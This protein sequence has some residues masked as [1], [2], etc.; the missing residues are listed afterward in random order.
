MICDICHERPA[1]AVKVTVVNG[2]R[3]QEAYCEKCL[4]EAIQQSPDP[5]AFLGLA[6]SPLA[7]M[8]SGGIDQFLAQVFGQAGQVFGLQGSTR[9][10][11]GAVP[12]GPG[13]GDTSQDGVGMMFGQF[14][15]AVPGAERPHRR[16]GGIASFAR[17]LVELA[18]AGRL[19]P[20]VG[21]EKEIN[22][23]IE[24]LG[25]KSKN[26]AVL[27]GDPGVGKTAIVE[28]LAQRIATGRVPEF[29]SGKH[30]W[31]LDLAGALAGT[32]YRGEFEARM[33]SLLSELQSRRDGI[34][35]IDELHT[36]L[37][38]G[39]A[40]GGM[41][42][43][44]ILK[45]VLARGDIQVIG[46]TTL[47]EY[48]RYIEKDGALSRR[49]QPIMVGEPTAAETLAILEGLKPAYESYHRVKISPE[50]LE[51]CVRL[52][53]R[54]VRDRFQP[55]KAIDVMD[56]AMARAAIQ[57]TDATLQKRL[58]EIKAEKEKAVAN[59]EF[60]RA[61]ALRDEERSLRAKLAGQK[62]QS[63]VGPDDVA[64]VVAEWT[65]IPVER[66]GS[67]ESARLVNLEER[68][69]RRVIGQRAALEEVARAI[70]RARSGLKDPRRPVGSFLFLGPTGV[71][72]TETARALAAEL[73][74]SED[75]MIRI[76]MSEYMEAHTVSRLIGS[77]PGY[78]GYED[79][80]QLTEA[81]R[82]HPY[83]VV[84]LDEFE[85]AHP[86]VQNVLLQVLDDGRLTDGQ[87]RTV[88]F[89]NTV[90]IMTSNLGT[91][92][93]RERSHGFVDSAG[94]EPSYQDEI[95]RFAL[96]HLR[97]EFVNRLDAIV[98]FNPLGEEELGQIVRLMVQ[99]LQVRLSEQKI[100]LDVTENAVQVIRQRGFDPV[101]GARPL[102][103]AVARLLADRIADMILAAKVHAG[104][105]IEADAQDGEIVL[106]VAAAVGA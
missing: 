22:R 82:R 81:V 68:L 85:K 97:P 25:R 88:D 39:D 50:A 3:Q 104:D 55:D 48:R 30:V 100:T 80:G 15:N 31:A 84:L 106:R 77:P 93:V 78:V 1:V 18:R 64:R 49:F 52:T 86:D 66:I 60:E 69:A 28:G 90:I 2:V 44:N 38:A 53:S 46:A 89:S 75:A 73:F 19:D 63:V 32:K 74:G 34:L 12:G 36:V 9:G 61:A 47:D 26:N 40:E 67:D 91:H 83:A 105:R 27:V 87:G 23:L 51:A 16:G 11:N 4:A 5:A 17:D 99:D 62:A 24:I 102:R 92:M 72:K 33:Q 42:A 70:R 59:Q 94:P 41:D 56:E 103:R 95:R 101:Y 58:E 13:T 29:L 10:Q 35:F 8:L 7:H 21:R 65:G 71:G 37:G 14:G 98:V 20:V 57:G 6:G 76:D 43:A 45:P 96:S 79:A 54:Y